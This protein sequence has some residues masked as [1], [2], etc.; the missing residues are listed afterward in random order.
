M[1]KRKELEEVKE[2]LHGFQ[3]QELKNGEVLMHF[4]DAEVT[5]FNKLVQQIGD[6]KQKLENVMTYGVERGGVSDVLSEQD[7][8]LLNI[9]LIENKKAKTA[10]YIRTIRYELG[11]NKDYIPLKDI[12]LQWNEADEVKNISK[13]K[14][15]QQEEQK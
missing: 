10:E 4:S 12:A 1:N 15:K 13:G 8:K 3:N 11:M 5:Y 9:Q 2:E 6:K 7:E 14:E